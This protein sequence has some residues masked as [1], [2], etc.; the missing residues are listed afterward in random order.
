MDHTYSGSSIY[1]IKVNGLLMDEGLINAH[2]ASEFD[3]PLTFIYGDDKTIEYISL[4]HPE[5][6]YIIS[7]RA[8]SRF[9]GEMYPYKTLLSQLKEKGRGLGTKKGVIPSMKKP[10][11]VEITFTDTTRAYIS[12]IIPGVSL[13]DYRKIRFTAEDFKEMYRYLMTVTHV[14]IAAKTIK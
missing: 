13:F 1:E 3:V 9:S 11:D 10:L 8:I 4:L 14:C 2:F 7:K 6:D 5:V 12:S